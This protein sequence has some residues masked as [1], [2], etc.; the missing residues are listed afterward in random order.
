MSMFQTYLH[1]PQKY[2]VDAIMVYELLD[3]I[4][5][6]VSIE[7]HFGVFRIHFQE[8]LFKIL[9]NKPLASELPLIFRKM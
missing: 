7:S 9:E 5:F 4:Q 1:N 8:G 2:P 6:G 3:E